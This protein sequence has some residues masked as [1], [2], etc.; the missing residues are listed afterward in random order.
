MIDI[1]EKKRIKWD[2]KYEF[3]I[4]IIK[5]RFR[6][7]LFMNYENEINAH[8]LSNIIYKNNKFKNFDTFNDLY[9]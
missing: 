8:V 9:Y 7:N 5:N 3:Y 2:L 4:N 1:V 6:N